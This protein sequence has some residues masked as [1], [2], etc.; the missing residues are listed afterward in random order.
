MKKQ[1]AKKRTKALFFAVIVFAV[2]VWAYSILGKKS[3]F[4]SDGGSGGL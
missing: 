3:F 2:A 1:K 4:S